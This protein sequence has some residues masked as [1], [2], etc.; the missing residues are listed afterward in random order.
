[1]LYRL[2]LYLNT[3]DWN[4]TTSW[5]V[6]F[7]TGSIR[8][9]RH[10]HFWQTDCE[11]RQ[12]LVFELW[13]NS[14]DCTIFLDELTTQPTCWTFVLITKTMC[15]LPIPHNVKTAATSSATQKNK[16]TLTQLSVVLNVHF[17]RKNDAN[18]DVN[19]PHRVLH[20]HVI[21][22]GRWT[23]VIPLQRNSYQRPQ[24]NLCL[25]WRDGLWLRN[26]NPLLHQTVAA[27]LAR[28]WCWWW[29]SGYIAQSLPAQ[30]IARRRLVPFNTEPE[31]FWCKKEK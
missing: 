4:K 25:K 20:V 29:G 11:T 16:P 5:L 15:L 13:P 26:I 21:R 24:T 30:L 17:Q 31:P 6:W 12:A 2:C 9:F 18:V 28:G 19:A 23:D 7:Q 10:S 1:M 8:Q 3:Q 27:C 22:T 14:I